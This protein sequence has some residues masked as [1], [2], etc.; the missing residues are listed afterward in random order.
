MSSAAEERCLGGEMSGVNIFENPGD[1]SQDDGTL[2]SLGIEFFESAKILAAAP[3]VSANTTAVAY[4]L[5]CHSAE[6]FIKAFLYKKLMPFEELKKSGHDLK[7]LVAAFKEH[8]DEL[9]FVNLLKVADHYNKKYFEYRKRS[10][11]AF[12]VIELLEQEVTELKSYVS[13]FLFDF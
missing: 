2:F 11:A 10:Y 13:S 8:A 7:K 1:G 3:V 12:G 9:E 4:Y 6:L 5:Y